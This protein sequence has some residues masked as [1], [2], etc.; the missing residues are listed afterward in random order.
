MSFTLI[1]SAETL[2]APFSDADFDHAIFCTNMSKTSSKTDNTNFTTTF[3]KEAKRIE[4]HAD[5]WAKLQTLK[6]ENNPDTVGLGGRTLT[7]IPCSVVPYNDEA[8]R[9][10]EDMGN[11]YDQVV[12][13]SERYRLLRVKHQERSFAA[14]VLADY[15]SFISLSI[16]Y[17]GGTFI[18]SIN[19]V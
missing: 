3:E 19:Q 10:I 12:S 11:N 6:A 18:Q 1:I 2:L 7:S 13:G 17:E 9:T 16:L 4:E 8:L 5:V 14:K 15:C